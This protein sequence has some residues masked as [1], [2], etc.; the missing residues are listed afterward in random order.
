MTKM[1]ER[2]EQRQELEQFANAGGQP[3]QPRG[4]ALVQP[5]RSLTP[6]GAQPVAHRRDNAEVRKQLSELGAMAGDDWFYRYPVKDN[7]TGQTTF[8]EG[9]SI[10]LANSVARV[11][12]NCITQISEVDQGDAWVFCATF[13][14]L[15]TGFSMERLYRQ[16]K[17]QQ[18]I[19]SKDPQRA[20]DIVYQIGQSKA[21]RNV[22]CNSL[23]IYTDFAFEQAQGS[24]VEKIGKDLEGWRRRTLEAL[25]KILVQDKAGRPSNLATE[26][27]RV[28]DI[29]GRPVRDWLATDIARI[30][31]MGKA[32]NDGM[33]TVDETFPPDETVTPPA[34]EKAPAQAAPKSGAGEA[35][36]AVGNSEAKP[37]REPAAPSSAPKNTAEYLAM[38]EEKT[39]A[40]PDAAALAQLRTWFVSD[41]QRKVRNAAGMVAE[42]TKQARLI[43]ERRVA[44]LN[45]DN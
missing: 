9:P 41:Q 39:R 6:I 40:V 30:V 21:I 35:T 19:N 4:H 2:N 34:P 17:G 43:I 1:S 12:G 11:V 27:K 15:E 10:K 5:T 45:R 38:V 3:N 7:R 8:I 29:I 24:L 42:D 16:R 36:A 44:E 31:A 37:E 28:T 22:I 23:Q 18:S 33:A 14:D 32:I 25:A 26:I 20:L 13:T